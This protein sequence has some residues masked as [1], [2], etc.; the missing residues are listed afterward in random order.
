MAHHFFDYYRRI[1]K[2]RVRKYNYFEKPLH[3]QRLFYFYKG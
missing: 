2:I 1:Q 3:L